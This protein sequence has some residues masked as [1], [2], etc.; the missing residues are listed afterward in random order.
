MKY[1][2]IILVLIGA[3]YSQTN[4]NEIVP[5]KRYTESIY[6]KEGELLTAPY[7]GWFFSRISTTRLLENDIL[8]A[9][10]LQENKNLKLKLDTVE[11]INEVYK[12]QLNIFKQSGT[13]PENKKEKVWENSLFLIGGWVVGV[14]STLL[15]VYIVENSQKN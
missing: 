8:A 11:G 13:L 1:I 15:I 2:F 14:S 6:V 10:L 5:Q 4:T 12:M 7:T 9:S 3:L